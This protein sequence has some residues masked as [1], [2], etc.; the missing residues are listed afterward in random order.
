MKQGHELGGCVALLAVSSADWLKETEKRR[1]AGSRLADF[2]GGK[3]KP[4]I[5]ELLGL[6]HFATL[7]K[8]N[9]R[10]RSTCMTPASHP[11]RVGRGRASVHRT[12]IFAVSLAVSQGRVA[13]HSVAQAALG[14]MSAGLAWFKK[15][16]EAPNRRL[17]PRASSS[18]WSL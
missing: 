12:A 14:W 1:A 5:N 8:G 13:A 4:D 10:S 2:K 6:A 17:S 11:A 9:P 18:C 3:I 15:E 16:A 7:K